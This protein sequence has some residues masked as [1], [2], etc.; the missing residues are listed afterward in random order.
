MTA[1]FLILRKK[2]VYIPLIV[3]AI[4]LVIYFSG[5]KAGK[6]KAEGEG[7]NQPLPNQTDWGKSLTEPE[8]KEIR[9]I[10]L[11]LKNSMEGIN[12]FGHSAKPYNDFLLLDDRFFIAVYNDFADI[13]KGNLREW[14]KG[15]TYTWN[16]PAGK[17]VPLIL[18]KFNK[19]NLA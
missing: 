13:S 6:Q 2:Q 18:E 3:I 12:W 11:A 17:V 5:K 8:S 15:E 19:L 10:A 9:R 16:D 4:I 1:I 14:L 7:K